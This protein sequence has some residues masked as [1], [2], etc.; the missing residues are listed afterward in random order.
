VNASNAVDRKMAR[1]GR[2]KFVSDQSLGSTKV[3]ACFQNGRE[4]RGVILLLICF[5]I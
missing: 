1:N 4:E 2:K 5:V 3:N